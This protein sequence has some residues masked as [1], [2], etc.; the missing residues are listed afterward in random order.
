MDDVLG[1]KINSFHLVPLSIFSLAHKRTTAVAV[2]SALSH[3][4][5]EQT[6]AMS[7]DI[8]MY[9]HVN[10]YFKLITS[11]HDLQS[12]CTTLSPTCALH[13]RLDCKASTLEMD[14]YMKFTNIYVTS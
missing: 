8:Y 13:G 2:A 14:L 6:N 10:M 3:S 12:D 9:L 1:K 11:F 4:A 5:F 7:L